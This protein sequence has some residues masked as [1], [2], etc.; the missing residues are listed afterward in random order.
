M[1]HTH[2][3]THAQH[4]G[5]AAPV[6]DASRVDIPLWLYAE[7][8]PHTDTHTHTSETLFRTLSMRLNHPLLT[9]YG[10][11]KQTM[12]TQT[13]VTSEWKKYFHSSVTLLNG[14]IIIIIINY[15]YYY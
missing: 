8:I 6:Q 3:H 1:K 12:G 14:I 2:T 13:V 4:T 7:V 9:F 15:Y 5:L 11:T 10:M